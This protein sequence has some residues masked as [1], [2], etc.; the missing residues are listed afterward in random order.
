MRKLI[1]G[2]WKMNGTIDLLR[3]FVDFF[4]YEHFI[5]AV[6]NIF[7]LFAKS[8]NQTAKI[9]AQDCSCF[10]NYGAY[11]GEISAKML[12]DCGATHVIIAHSERRAN[13]NE[14]GRIVK[15]K[16]Q[17]ALDA[18]LRIIYCVNEQYQYQIEQEANDILHQII[19]AYEPITAIG[20]GQIP[21]LDEILHPIKNIKKIGAKSVLYGG[22]VNSTNVQEILTNTE[23]DGVLV[24]GASTKQE[25]LI[26]IL[27]F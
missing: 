13:F 6:P 27:Q 21:T 15:N 14:N 9:A 22:S 25:E 11:T 3:N 2:N 7:I 23:I 8:L 16:I 18:G 17:N 19:V 5:L 20:T 26:K 1:V 4:S 24:G 12:K 10:A